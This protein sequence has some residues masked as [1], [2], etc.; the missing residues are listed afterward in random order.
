MR[1]AVLGGLVLFSAGAH[2][3]AP[4]VDLLARLAPTAGIDDGDRLGSAVA[5]DG[6]WA[7]VGAV[8]DSFLG[9]PGA[10]SAF[11]FHRQSGQ[12]VLSARLDGLS[13]GQLPEEKRAFG[14]SVAIDGG[15][16]AV[17]ARRG[18][19]AQGTETGAVH[20]FDR[21]G[22]DWTQT[23]VVSAPVPDAGFGQVIAL[24]GSRLLIGAPYADDHRGRAYLAEPTTAGWAI[25][26]T[27]G[28]E[29]EGSALFGSDLDLDG[30]RAAVWRHSPDAVVVFERGAQGW[31]ESFR[32]TLGNVPYQSNR[33]ALSGDRLAVDAVE[34]VR[35]YERSGGP[36]AAAPSPDLGGGAETAVRSEGVDL[37]GQTLAVLLYRGFGQPAVLAAYRRT[38][39]GWRATETPVD[40]SRSSYRLLEVA[41]SGD[42]VL[43][44]DMFAQPPTSERPTS[45]ESGAAV[46]FTVGDVDAP[47]RVDTLGVPGA[48]RGYAQAG[49][50]VDYDGERLAVAEAGRGVVR[51]YRGVTSPG[52][53]SGTAWVEEAVLR[54]GTGAVALEG[55]RLLVGSSSS[56]GVLAYQ[57]VGDEWVADGVLGDTRSTSATVALDGTHA[58]VGNPGR[59]SGTARV[60]RAGAAGWQLVST[61][62]EDD[63][64]FGSAVAV[65]GSRALVASKM[66]RRDGEF[67]RVRVYE[68]RGGQWDLAGELE[69]V[70]GGLF[71]DRVAIDGGRMLAS[72]PA[73]LGRSDAQ[74]VVAVYEGVR[75]VRTAVLASP[76]PRALFG[77][78]LALDGDRVVVG[79]PVADRQGDNSGAAFLFEYDGVSW[80]RPQDVTAERPHPDARFGASVAVF[81]PRVVVGAP[82]DSED[83]LGAGAAFVYQSSFSTPSDRRPAPARAGLSIP[84]PN[85]TS[86]RTALWLTVDR[87]SDAQVVVYDALGRRVA[88]LHQGQFDT[89]RHQLAVDAG[90][91][92]PGVY[93]VRAVVA[94]RT[95]VQRLVVAR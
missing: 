71:G 15:R 37:D 11:V 33:L 9:S 50:H 44:G 69:P 58:V 66:Q 3:Q 94:D 35:V 31:S 63:T 7:V 25:T 20:V 87:P 43:V 21:V 56:G 73:Y 29:G 91:L 70:A 32:D 47:W 93:L 89:G 53:P 38:E 12:W 51:V 75:P 52:R 61:F 82:R 19:G 65:S 85:P 45:D 23:A 62:E 67:G 68:D 84:A 6:D 1:L 92:A 30:D 64:E 74:E 81:G 16:I 76:L 24:S 17:G 4:R 79:A 49:S 2:A 39:D 46:V 28:G 10:G 60:Y 34:T 13:P 55:G 54:G 42:R 48:P 5:I 14:V 27:F 77:A 80:S 86:G 72:A 78:A 57:R 90:A 18:V 26:E 83:A 95:D 88:T 22:T 36:W 59:D 41:L 8:G 40:V